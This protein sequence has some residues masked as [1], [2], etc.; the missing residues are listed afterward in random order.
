[1]ALKRAVLEQK[2]KVRLYKGPVGVT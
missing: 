1:M 2:G